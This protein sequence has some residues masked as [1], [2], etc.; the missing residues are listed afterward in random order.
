MHETQGLLDKQHHIIIHNTRPLLL[1]L[2]GWWKSRLISADLIVPCK[3]KQAKTS[4]NKPEKD[5]RA[6]PSLGL[7]KHIQFILCFEA[8][9]LQ[10]L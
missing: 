1:G 8:K 10:N 3:R 4:R 6:G 2:F 7:T 9:L 5:K